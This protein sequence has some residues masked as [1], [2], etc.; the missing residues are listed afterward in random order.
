MRLPILLA[1]CL[2]FVA[3]SESVPDYGVG[4]FRGALLD[5]GTLEPLPARPSELEADVEVAVVPKPT[6]EPEEPEP[7]VIEAEPEPV[8]EPEAETE[9][10]PVSEPT[11]TAVPT[12]IDPDEEVLQLNFD[13]MA[14]FEY[15]PPTLD[16]IDEGTL[17]PNQIPD[18]VL[19][20]NNK[21]VEIEGYMIPIEVEQGKVQSFILS[22]TLSGCCFGDMPNIQEWVDVKMQEDRD[23]DYIP[24]APVLVIGRI[25]VGEVVDEYGITSLYRMIAESVEDPW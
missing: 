17:R 9:E 21:V 10:I 24:Y 1:T 5:I 16:E 23:A 19:A 11:E 14:D 25:S 2:S 20:F 22:R 15:T 8:V 3:C 4:P 18:S 7:V 13:D 12:E 6:I